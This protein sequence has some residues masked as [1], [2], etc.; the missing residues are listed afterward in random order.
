M[1]KKLEGNSSLSDHRSSFSRTSQASKKS[2]ELLEFLKGEDG[3]FHHLS[4]EEL[5]NFNRYRQTTAEWSKE[6]IRGILGLDAYIHHSRAACS[7]TTGGA[8]RI[9]VGKPFASHDPAIPSIYSKAAAGG[10]N[11]ALNSSTSFIRSRRL[12]SKR[13]LLDQ[14]G[15]FLAQNQVLGK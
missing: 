8:S 5:Q 4:K 7:S 2:L 12:S 15:H 11:D 1:G 14:S 10:E 6:K 9:P 13:L 3:Q